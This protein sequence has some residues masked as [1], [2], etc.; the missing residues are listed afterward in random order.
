MFTTSFKAP[1]HKSNRQFQVAVTAVV[2]NN[3]KTNV[4]I[5]SLFSS[6]FIYLLFYSIVYSKFSDKNQLFS[7]V[8]FDIILLTI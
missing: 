7:F 6:K 2:C 4:V 5:L 3:N 1:N 8:K